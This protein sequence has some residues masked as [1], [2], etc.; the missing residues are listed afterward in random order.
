MSRIGDQTGGE[1]YN[2][3]GIRVTT[4]APYFDDIT[5]RLQRQYDVAF[6]PK[7]QYKAG[8]VPIRV[9]TELPH[10]DLVAQD[11]VWVEGGE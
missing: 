7:P 1:A 2:I 5:G 4:L 6:R 8:F 3:T 11:R 10:V 9:T